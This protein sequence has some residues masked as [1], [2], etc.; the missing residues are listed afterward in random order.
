MSRVFNIWYDKW[1]PNGPLIKIINR[2]VI[3]VAGLSTEA[4]VSSMIND[5]NWLWPVEWEGIFDQV[6]NNI[7][8][9]RL[10]NDVNDNAAWI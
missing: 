10:S 1:F 6:I 7:Y 5:N 3:E 2:R 4:C 9:P 8:V